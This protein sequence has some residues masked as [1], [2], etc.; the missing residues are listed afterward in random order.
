MN[1]TKNLIWVLS[2]V[3]LCALA[4][5]FYT[6]TN[7]SNTPDTNSVPVFAEDFQTNYQEFSDGLNNPDSLTTYP[8]DEY[9]T[10]I[11]QKSIYYIDIN[12]DGMPERITKTFI[13]TGNAHSYYEYK[14][15][16]NIDGKFID[17][18]PQNLR[19]TNGDNCDLQ[20]IQFVFKPDFKI[21]LIYRELGE[22]WNE[23]TM[24]KKQIF[25]IID[26]K[27][28]SGKIQTLRNICDVKKLF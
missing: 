3:L 28:Q 12:N 13:E 19:T 27:I 14:I 18:T 6:K 7:K 8:L 20:Q 1:K 10:G 4:F 24:A 21:V 9:G 23:P 5:V 11:S 16:L 26:N 2:V 25:S 22:T 15:E 17:I